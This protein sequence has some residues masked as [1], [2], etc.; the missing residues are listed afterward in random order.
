M[1]HKA[2]NIKDN[3]VQYERVSR[4]KVSEIQKQ[5]AIKI[6]DAIFKGIIIGKYNIN[7]YMCFISAIN[8]GKLFLP[9]I[10]F[11]NWTFLWR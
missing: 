9:R 7:D 8:S 6:G 2:I 1:F 3:I 11:S 5:T 10:C 4:K